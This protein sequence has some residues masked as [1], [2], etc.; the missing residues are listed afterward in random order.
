MELIS[1][2]DEARRQLGLPTPSVEEY[3]FM[4]GL[5]PMK[6]FVYNGILR[7]YGIMQY[8]RATNP[9]TIRRNAE[10]RGKRMARFVLS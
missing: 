10:K 1:A 3:D 7:R 5:K 2:D 9:E 8:T 4:R 6:K